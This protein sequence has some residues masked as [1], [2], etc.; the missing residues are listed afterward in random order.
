MRGC[1]A[2]LEAVLGA[3]AVTETAS[4]RVFSDRVGDTARVFSDRAVDASARVFFLTV[5]AT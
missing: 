5:W 4:A 2:G 1:R 3:S